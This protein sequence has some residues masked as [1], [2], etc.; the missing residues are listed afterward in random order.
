MEGRTETLAM[1]MLLAS[2]TMALAG[3]PAGNG[4]QPAPKTTQ[5]T[6]PPPAPEP[7]PKP[8]AVKTT[9]P[10]MVHIEVASVEFFG[11]S[12][13]TVGEVLADNS[14][15][16]KIEKLAA[17]LQ[18]HDPGPGHKGRLIICGHEKADFKVIKKV[19]YTGS[20]TGYT[21]ASVGLTRAGVVSRC[22]YVE[23]KR[24]PY[25]DRP[26]N[27]L[28]PSR[29]LSLTL[30][31][32][33]D[34]YIVFAGPNRL[35]IPK[36]GGAFDDVQLIAELTK[37]RQKL[38]DKEDLNVAPEDGVLLGDLIKTLGIVQKVGFRYLRLSDSG[39]SL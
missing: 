5:K 9:G 31:M 14:N 33:A 2:L 20:V 27:E 21:R 23:L 35:T 38:P 25:Q 29:R 34:G 36:K 12:V 26:R 18:G 3:C 8:S 24:A 37:I 19:V 28:S 22:K 32:G 7:A 11:R 15:K 6:A 10:A 13:A 4:K 1:T 39:A 17:A 16:W 30:I